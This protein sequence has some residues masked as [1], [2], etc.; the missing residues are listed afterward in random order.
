MH[1]PDT[2]CKGEDGEYSAGAPT[3]SGESEVRDV[4][5]LYEGG[6]VIRMA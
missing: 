1:P 4:N 5:E 6:P 3:A 2:Y